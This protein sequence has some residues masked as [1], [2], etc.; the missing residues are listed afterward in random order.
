[1][2]IE[3]YPVGWPVNPWKPEPVSAYLIDLPEITTRGR[4]LVDAVAKLRALVPEALAAL[5][6]EGTI[7]PEPSRDSA[8]QVRAIRWWRGALVGSTGEVLQNAQ[9]EIVVQLIPA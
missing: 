3:Y 8:F 5:R 4:N 1:M 9:P 6:R 2:K 7:L